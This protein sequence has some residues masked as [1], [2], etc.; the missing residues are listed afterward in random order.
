MPEKSK[1]TAVSLIIARKSI[2]DD[3]DFSKEQKR[4]IIKSLNKLHR[5]LYGN[6]FHYRNLVEF[7]GKGKTI[8]DCEN[9]FFRKRQHIANML[10]ENNI[11]ATYINGDYFYK[12]PQI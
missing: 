9:Y 8:Q 12:N 4:E 2:L 5:K 11:K 10:C 3:N 7:L 1:I 6:T